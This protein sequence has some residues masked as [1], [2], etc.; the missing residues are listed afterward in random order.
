LIYIERIALCSALV[1]ILAAAVTISIDVARF[2]LPDWRHL[3]SI[4]AA[5][6]PALALLL[7]SYSDRLAID[8]Q[9]KS[10]L[11]M[12]RVFSQIQKRLSSHARD[13]DTPEGF[14][15]VLGVEALSE[16]A[17]WLVL[18]KSKPPSMPN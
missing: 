10:A 16:C 8:E 13:K 2:D 1:G 18:R 6:L 14:I 17:N 11:R 7:Q 15:H 4:S 12:Q 5:V 9:S 3:T